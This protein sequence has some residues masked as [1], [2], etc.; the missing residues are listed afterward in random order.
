MILPDP[1]DEEILP[2]DPVTEYTS[3]LAGI[4]IKAGVSQNH[5]AHIEAHT[6][7]MRMVQ[8]SSLPVEKGQAVMAVLSAHI[9][10]HMGLQVLVDVAT[11]LNLPLEAMGPDMP[12]DIEAQ[13]APAIATAMAELEALRVPP[14]P[15]ASIEQIKQQ[16]AE[17]REL[18]KAQSQAARDQAAQDGKMVETLLRQEHDREMAEIK[19]RHAREIQDIKDAAAMDR[20]IE[21]NT[22]AIKV[23][24]L[25]HSGKSAGADAGANS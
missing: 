13:L 6:I 10:E 25:R 2:A 7:Q 24:R 23:A 9:A 1:Q 4:P 8:N 14:D 21:D 11:R 17:R 22:A 12:P 20:E 16:G 3:A 18:I 5:A 19:A 15:A